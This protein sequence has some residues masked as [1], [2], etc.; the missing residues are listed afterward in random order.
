MASDNK[1]IRRGLAL[2][3]MASAT[4]S[5][6]GDGVRRF[7]LEDPLWTDPDTRPIVHKPAPRHTADYAVAAE[8]AVFRPLSRAL[9]LPL[10]REALNVNSMDE[11]PNS[12][13]FTNRIGLFPQD[14]AVTARAACGTAPALD[15]A[16]GRWVVLSGKVDGG[17]AGFAMKAPDGRRYLVKVDG[18]LQGTRA[19][20]A[21]VVGSV[22]Y[23]AAGYHVPC[24]QIVHFREDQL[25][26]DPAATR[27]DPHGK[28]VPFTAADLTRVLGFASRRPDGSIRASASLYLEGDPL[29]PFRF[30]GVRND[31]PNDIVPHERRRELR[32]SM[33]LAAWIHHWDTVDNNTLDMFVGGG[34]R[35]F[36]RHHFI[37]WSDSLGGPTGPW[38]RV[39]RRAGAGEAHYLQFGHVFV[40]FLTLGLYPRPWYHRIAPPQAGEFDYFGSDGF[41]ASKWRPTFANAAFTELTPRDGLWAARIISRFSDAHIRA[42]V[43]QAR[44]DEP[45][46]EAFL[47]QTLSRRRDLILREYFS[48]LSPLDRFT[49]ENAAA[50]ALGQE[51][52]FVDL[53]LTTGLFEPRST[54]YRLVFRS[55]TRLEEV[56][57]WRQMVPDRSQ[58]AQCVPLPL[59]PR[60][61][62]H[63]SGAAAAA[64]DP[65]RYGVLQID[66]GSPASRRPAA[67]VLVHLYDLGPDRG[68]RMVGIERPYVVPERGR[69]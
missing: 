65:R 28:Q 47:I 20:T 40:D 48:S 59:G 62:A 45:Q 38:E 21:D 3:A 57:G 55:G 19:T 43:G 27:K 67:T 1:R 24:N 8:Q 25:L 42:I 32:G 39:N 53:A 44:L 60:R 13:W 49:L 16:A 34:G 54:D 69:E 9:T 10:R 30:D 58:P 61:P 31:D 64:D 6:T 50:P 22:I 37:D 51:L 11:V 12:S 35:G 56:L 15:P 36:I 26:L 68:F 63:L 18:F 29:G 14:P 66:N 2:L 33:L 4:V 41:V 23:H 7:P 46:V 52:C 17:T 5:C